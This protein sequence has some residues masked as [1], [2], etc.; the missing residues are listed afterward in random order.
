MTGG[1]SIEREVRITVEVVDG[2]DLKGNENVRFKEE[3]LL[4]Y[5][6]EGLES[7][8]EVEQ[9]LED[10]EVSHLD[11]REMVGGPEFKVSK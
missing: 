10:L 3:F 1:F 8:A 7:L 4:G 9:V 11:D 5:L 2:F 6:G